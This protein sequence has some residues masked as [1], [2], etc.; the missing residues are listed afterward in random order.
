MVSAVNAQATATT[1]Q[2]NQAKYVHIDPS[3][4]KGL[5]GGGVGP[6]MFDGVFQAIILFGAILGAG[7][8]LI[9]GSVGF[10]SAALLTQ[11]YPG[12]NP[13]L[14]VVGGVVGAVGALVFLVMALGSRR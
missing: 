10:G 2:P 1:P 3:T 4:Y 5:K 13:A 11:A 6:G 12:A 14:L 7:A 9:A 8:L